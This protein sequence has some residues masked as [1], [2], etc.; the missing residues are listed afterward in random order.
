M[1][2]RGK[3][4]INPTFQKKI[5]ISVLGLIC[6]VSFLFIGTSIYFFEKMKQLGRIAG[7]A[8]GHVYFQFVE[9]QSHQYMIISGLGFLLITI[10]VFIW[11][12]RMSHRIA[13]PFYNLCQSVDEMKKSGELRKIKFRDGDFFPEVADSVNEIIGMKG[14]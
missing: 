5:I 9:N 12:L 14:G 13:G 10:F 3:F 2:R 1:E 4:F 7:L 11:A 6:L 8:E